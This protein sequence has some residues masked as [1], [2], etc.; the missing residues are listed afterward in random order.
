MDAKTDHSARW[1]VPSSQPQRRMFGKRVWT[2]V[3]MI[4][5]L[6]LFCR[7]PGG[8]PGG[9]KESCARHAC[10]HMTDTYDFDW[11]KVIS[12]ARPFPASFQLSKRT[13]SNRLKISNGLHAMMRKNV[14]D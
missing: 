8:L 7:F 2:V 12:G 3:A 4:L 13:S 6:P 10:K 1:Y 14:P 5:V 11:Y 9:G